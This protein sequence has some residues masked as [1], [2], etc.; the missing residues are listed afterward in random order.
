M[1]P[2]PRPISIRTFASFAGTTTLAFWLVIHLSDAS[3]PWMAEVLAPRGINAG[4]ALNLIWLSAGVAFV[5][6]LMWLIAAR[7]RDADVSLGWAPAAVLPL[8]ALTILND[9]I[10]LVSRTFVLPPLVNRGLIL[11][12]AAVAAWVL[13]QCL[14][15][16]SRKA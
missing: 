3:L 16:P 7:L 8:A 12:A 13:F 11:A 5:A 6:A 15:R 2:R 10:F 14:V 9:A 1:R 4:F